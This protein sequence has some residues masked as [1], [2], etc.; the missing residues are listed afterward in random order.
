MIRDIKAKNKKEE[1]KLKLQRRER[2]EGTTV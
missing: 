1:M 2:R